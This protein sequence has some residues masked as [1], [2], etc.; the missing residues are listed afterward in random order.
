VGGGRQYKFFGPVHSALA[1]LLQVNKRNYFC[2]FE[3]F[4]NNDQT[5]PVAIMSVLRGTH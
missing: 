5:L 2:F 4:L 3:F 1:M